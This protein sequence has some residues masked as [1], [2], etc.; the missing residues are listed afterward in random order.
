LALRRLR[1][2]RGL[3]GFQEGFE[4]IEGISRG[5]WGDWGLWGLWGDWGV[6]EVLLR[7]LAYCIVKDLRRLESKI[8]VK[9]KSNWGNVFEKCM[10]NYWWYKGV[11][12]FSPSARSGGAQNTS[13]L[14][15]R[16]PRLARMPSRFWSG[17]CECIS[18]MATQ[19]YNPHMHACITTN[20]TDCMHAYMSL[21]QQLM[22]TCS[23][24]SMSSTI[25]ACRKF[26]HAMSFLTSS[27]RLYYYGGCILHIL[28]SADHRR[29]C[30]TTGRN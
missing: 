15:T 19:W 25:M 24:N 22:H 16:H 12:L 27:A 18:C 11:T 7:L 20:I 13:S 28:S 9:L 10:R 3:R 26:R 6:W 17:V 30:L 23:A 14:P 4:G 1:A 21:Q 5:L 29:P 8:E 2:L